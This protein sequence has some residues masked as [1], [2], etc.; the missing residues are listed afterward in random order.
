ME[1]ATTSLSS[2]L[3]ECAF[4]LD[5]DGTILDIAPAPQEYGCR[6]RCGRRSAACRS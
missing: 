1:I 4:L 3:R 6:R 5:I 2:D